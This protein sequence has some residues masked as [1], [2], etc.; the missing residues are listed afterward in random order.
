[1]ENAGYSDVIGNSAAPY[2]NSMAKNHLLFTNS[3]AVTHPSEPNYLALFAGT[4]EGLTTDACPLAY[5]GSTIATELA[6]KGRR[7]TLFAEQLPSDDSTACTAGA[8]SAVASK[9]LYWRKHDPAADFPFVSSTETQPWTGSGTTPYGSA[10]VSFIIPNICN[11]MHDCGV[12]SGDAWAAA[13]IPAIEAY[14]AA[15][16]GLL[17]LTFDEAEYDSTNH[18]VTIFDG[19][20]LHGSTSQYVTHYAVLRY[21][22]SAF[23]LPYAAN[24]ASASAISL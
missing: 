22:E 13:N 11:D 18:I 8:D 7:F 21:I 12:A 1:M 9:Y 16:N 15:H 5:G 23:G 3:H 17:I 2:I 10:D 24:S 14:N 6:A 4:T 19:L 20:G